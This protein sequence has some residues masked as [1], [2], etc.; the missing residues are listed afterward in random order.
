[1]KEKKTV[2]AKSLPTFSSDIKFQFFQVCAYLLVY[3]IN[4]SINQL[5]DQLLQVVTKQHTHTLSIKNHRK[6]YASLSCN[7]EFQLD[8]FPEHKSFSLRAKY[9]PSQTGWGL[10]SIKLPKDALE[11]TDCSS[12]FTS[13]ILN[14]F[15]YFS[16]PKMREVFEILNWWRYTQL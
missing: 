3:G 5:L 13:E 6:I 4:E 7:Q 2:C 11:I 10:G 14:R 8:F 1:M 12:Q 15:W 16:L 9:F